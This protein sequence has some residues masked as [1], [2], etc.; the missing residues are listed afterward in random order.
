MLFTAIFLKLVSQGVDAQDFIGSNKK[1]YPHPHVLRGL[2]EN[3]VAYTIYESQQKKK[4]HY[5]HSRT[6]YHL[7]ATYTHFTPSTNSLH[8]PAWFKK[9]R[10]PPIW[11]LWYCRIHTSHI[12]DIANERVQCLFSHS[13]CTGCPGYQISYN[14]HCQ[15][16]WIQEYYRHKRKMLYLVTITEFLWQLLWTQ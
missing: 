3:E 11:L 13:H 5:V 6:S 16:T 8:L 10:S 14:K 15:R 9:F 7:K 12:C 4:K 2:M 1:N